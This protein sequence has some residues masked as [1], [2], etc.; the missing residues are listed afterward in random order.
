MKHECDD[1]GPIGTRLM[2]CHDT[3]LCAL[4]KGYTLFGLFQ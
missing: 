3:N 2:S 1:G 4:V